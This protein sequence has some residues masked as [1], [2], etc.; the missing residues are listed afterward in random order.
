MKE[1]FYFNTRITQVE[2]LGRTARNVKEL[3]EGIKRVPSS[4][5]YH[6]THKYLEQ[7]RFFSPEHPND[8]SYWINTSLGLKKLAEKIASI[9]IIQFSGIEDLRAKF[10]QILGDYL[11]DSPFLRNCIPSEEFR[12]L[13]SKIFVLP[14]PFVAHN[15]E[16]FGEALKRVTVR[17]FYFHMFEARLRLKKPDNDFSCWLRDQGYIRLA[18][19]VSQLDP[20]TYTLEGLRRNLIRLV[21]EEIR[22]DR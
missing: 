1:P 4:S 22:D 14:T 6:H 20:Y 19:K 5:I 13:S 21:E 9:D 8:F 3:L 7:H 17:S 10:I 2:L 16:E 12:F 18:E 15:L 11:K